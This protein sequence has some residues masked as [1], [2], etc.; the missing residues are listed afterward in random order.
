MK[1]APKFLLKGAVYRLL[2]FVRVEGNFQ[3]AVRF[4]FFARHKIVI[5]HEIRFIVFAESRCVST[6]TI[7]R[8]GGKFSGGCQ[9]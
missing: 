4:R 6:F 9:V 7:R 3:E 5:S 8:R 2:L 1:F